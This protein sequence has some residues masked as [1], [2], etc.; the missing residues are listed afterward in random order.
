MIFV[1]VGTG[2]FDALVRKM[3]SLKLKEKVVMQVGAGKCLPRNH[4]YF[5][6]STSLEKYYRK[7]SIIIGHGGTATLLEAIRHRAKVIG[8]DNKDRPDL[9]QKDI[10]RHLDREGY[11]LWCRDL[12]KLGECI[13]KVR[14]MKL[15]KYV[16]PK[17]TIPNVIKKFL[18]E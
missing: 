16:P 1:T 3:D 10:V 9:H 5:R 15:R 12:E 14:K 13:R 4:E 6:F 18:N 7:A 11:I 17:C 8:V 2:D